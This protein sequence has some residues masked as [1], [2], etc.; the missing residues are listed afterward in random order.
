MHVEYDKQ[1]MYRRYH[2]VSHNKTS[3]ESSVV[4]R[5]K[6]QANLFLFSEF[7]HFDILSKFWKIIPS[8]NQ[9]L[10]RQGKTNEDLHCCECK[11]DIVYWFSHMCICKTW[12]RIRNPH[13]DRHQ[14]GNSVPDRHQNNADSQHCSN[15]WRHYWTQ[16]SR[17][18]LASA[19]QI[20]WPFQCSTYFSYYLIFPPPLPDPWLIRQYSG[21]AQVT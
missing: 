2:M 15:V 17:M 20:L 21:K 7:Q 9:R 13:V 19:V 14:N 11:L 4:D 5:Y 16:M 3:L 1:V 12:D 6:F 18:T 8:I 10:W